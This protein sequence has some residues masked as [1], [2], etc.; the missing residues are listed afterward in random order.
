MQYYWYK[1]IL[2]DFKN[3]YKNVYTKENKTCFFNLSLKSLIS[4]FFFFYFDDE[5]KKE[6]FTQKYQ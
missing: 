3:S 2:Q 6:I 1:G 5:N 4:F